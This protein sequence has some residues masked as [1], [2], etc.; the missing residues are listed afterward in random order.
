MIDPLIDPGPVDAIASYVS[1][2]LDAISTGMPALV[3]RYDASRQCCDAQPLVQRIYP[4]EY[5]NRVAATEPVVVAVPVVYPRSAAGGLEFPLAPGDVVLLVTCSRSIQTW[6]R[7]A[8]PNAPTDPELESSHELGHCVAIPCARRMR[9][10]SVDFDVTSVVLR[11]ESIKLGSP[12]AT[13]RVVGDSALQ[14]FGLALN[15]AIQTLTS[16]SAPPAAVAVL[17]LQALA[18]ALNISS[19]D[20]SGWG[21][22]TTSTK[23]E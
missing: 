14:T 2:A 4:D 15:A 13:Q 9:D 17:A 18:T 10:V 11:G 7:S 23:V 12:A 21:A 20:G 5:G 22:G 6:W 19:V 1:D 16:S 8:G 3:T